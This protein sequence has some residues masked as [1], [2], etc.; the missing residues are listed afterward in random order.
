M[1]DL[2]ALPASRDTGGR[3]R[4]RDVL[5]LLGCLLLALVIRL[6]AA[7]DV[8]VVADEYLYCNQAQAMRHGNYGD[9]DCF[10]PPKPGWGLAQGIL[11]PQLMALLSYIV[12]DYERAGR[13]ISV[14]MGTLTILPLWL[15]GSQLYGRRA[16]HFSA[17]LWAL[18]PLH[19]QWSTAVYRDATYCCLVTAY[20]FFLWEAM[21]RRQARFYFGAGLTWAL[22]YMTRPE[23]LVYGLLALLWL[24]AKIRFGDKREF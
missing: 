2:K 12:P 9:L 16:A 11:Y 15:L 3:L 23:G 18:H 24:P 7:H 21:Q 22:A 8:V 5:L 14:L 19:V 17:L 4:K 1:D 6:I 10:V 13:F 20:G